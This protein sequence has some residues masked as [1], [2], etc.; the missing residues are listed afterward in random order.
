MRSEPATNT[1][2]VVFNREGIRREMPSLIPL[3]ARH[4]FR[5][6][7]LNFCEMLNRESTLNTP[8]A[9]KYIDLLEEEKNEYGLEFIQAH[10]PYPVPGLLDREE[11]LPL[12]LRSMEFA[13]RLGV[14]H[15]V[16][17][18]EGKNIKDNIEYFDRILSSSRC[19]I[20]IALEN[21][22]TENEISRSDE[23][24][25]IQS[26]FGSRMGICFDIGHAHVLGL[27][28]AEEISAYGSLMIGTHIHDNDGTRD[29]HL[30]PFYGNIDWQSAMKAFAASYSG[31]INYEAMFFSRTRPMAEQD[32]I[33]DEA[34][35][36]H[37]R[38]VALAGQIETA[39]LLV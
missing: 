18:P 19:D 34:M 36:L 11:C 23:L 6:L 2:L 29:Q 38:L 27:D 5:H 20:R 37:S 35:N 28:I 15:I 39:P 21:M 7:D 4:G 16:I 24:L 32:A 1:N 14:P 31:F 22:E 9:E 8:E 25:E 10:A 3:Y 12:V 26:A 17:H 30:L 13:S 33:I